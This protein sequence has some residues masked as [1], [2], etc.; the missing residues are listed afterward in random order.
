[1]LHFWRGV[2]LVHDTLRVQDF[3]K[4]IINSLKGLYLFQPVL[5]DVLWYH[6]VNY[7]Y[8]NKG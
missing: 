8:T 7:K 4:N 3:T 5:Q 6:Q 2:N 1:M